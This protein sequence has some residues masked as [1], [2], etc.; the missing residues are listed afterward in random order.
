MGTADFL[1]RELKRR[2]QR[3]ARYSLRAFARDLD[4]DP[5]T[6]SQWL[7]GARPMS[8]EAEGHLF[9]RLDLDPDER[10]RAR[11]LDED[12]LRVFEAVR[13]S[14][15]TTHQLAQAAGV[16]VDRANVALTKWLRLH[17]VRLD[18]S[19]W[20]ILEDIQ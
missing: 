10:A 4:C 20:Q 3:N 18:Q 16:T 15:T 1:K 12:D 17:V 13:T 14:P 19:R 8:A 11:E 7:R 9:A 5:A 2:Q 6:L